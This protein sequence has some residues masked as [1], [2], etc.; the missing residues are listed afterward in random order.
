[1]QLNKLCFFANTSVAVDN[2]GIVHVSR[3]ISYEY[4]PSLL[5]SFASSFFT[6]FRCRNILVKSID[7]LIFRDANFRDSMKQCNERAC[8]CQQ[9]S[10]RCCDSVVVKSCCESSDA[11]WQPLEDSM[12]SCSTEILKF[13]IVVLSFVRISCSLGLFLRMCIIRFL[14]GSMFCK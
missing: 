4:I 7:V 1:M 11:I 10:L 9:S 3:E 13:Q 5:P 8:R 2:H 12:T 6:H 14:P